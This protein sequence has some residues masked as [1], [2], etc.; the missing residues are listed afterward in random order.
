MFFSTPKEIKKKIK[1]KQTVFV[2]VGNLLFSKGFRNNKLLKT[3]SV[4]SYLQKFKNMRSH[5]F[6]KKLVGIVCSK[7]ITNEI[8]K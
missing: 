8:S 7:C 6:V 5:P 4:F 1:I 2:P 3:F